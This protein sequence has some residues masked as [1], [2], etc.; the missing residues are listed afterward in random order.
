MVQSL[1]QL[2]ETWKDIDAKKLKLDARKQEVN[3]A[4][5]TMRMELIDINMKLQGID[6]VRAELLP[7]IAQAAMDQGDATGASA[8]QLPPLFYRG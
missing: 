8:P 7:K 1:F 3:N 6:L 2:H 5:M 4:L